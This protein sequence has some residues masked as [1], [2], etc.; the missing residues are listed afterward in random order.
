M[1]TFDG[2]K[3]GHV[4]NMTPGKNHTS[5]KL[6]DSR[7]TS[8]GVGLKCTCRMVYIITVITT[9]WLPL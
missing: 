4:D 1:L 8:C 2:E 3:L 9:Y 7:T 5:L 6:I